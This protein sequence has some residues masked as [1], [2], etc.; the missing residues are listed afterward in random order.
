[1]LSRKLMKIVEEIISKDDEILVPARK[2]YLLIKYNH[3][4]IS[5]PT[6]SEFVSALKRS[7]KFDVIESSES[8]HYDL[9]ESVERILMQ[10][11][12]Y[13]T[14]PRVKLRSVKLTPKLLRE[15]FLKSYQRMRAGVEEL[16]AK[17]S[18]ESDLP[19]EEISKVVASFAEL[20]E[21][22]NK[23]IQMLEKL[24]LYEATVNPKKKK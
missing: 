9:P 12:I 16:L 7:R 14:G 24:E 22:I 21:Q 3:K 17:I 13:G 10:V 5:L 18:L 20:R 23:T 1:M 11:G 2:I 6:F 15:T 8:V 19:Q 4:D